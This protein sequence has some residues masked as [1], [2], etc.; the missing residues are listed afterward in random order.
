M[1]GCLEKSRGVCV[2]VCVRAQTYTAATAEVCR[3]S[4]DTFCLD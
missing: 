2:R 1:H 3:Y 4:V